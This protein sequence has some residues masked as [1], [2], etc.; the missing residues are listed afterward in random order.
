MVGAAPV[1][2]VLA[3]AVMAASDRPCVALPSAQTLVATTVV[4]VFLDFFAAHGDRNCVEV[5]TNSKLVIGTG[6]QDDAI[7]LAFAGYMSATYVGEIAV[8]CHRCQ[9]HVRSHIQFH[10]P[11]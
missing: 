2:V 3:T 11:V 8:A 4:S 6:D 1:L 7:A 10:L 5:A 9:T